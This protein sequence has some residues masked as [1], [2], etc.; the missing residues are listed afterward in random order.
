MGTSMSPTRALLILGAAA[1]GALTATACAQILGADFDV[2]LADAGPDGGAGG[3][4]FDGGSVTSSSSSS[5]GSG[6]GDAGC[7][8]GK[9]LA[10][11]VSKEDSPRGIATAGHWVY[12]TSDGSQTAEGTIKRTDV[13][14]PVPSASKLIEGLTKPNQIAVDAAHV[15][16]TDTVEGSVYCMLLSGAITPTHVVSSE[17]GPIGILVDDTSVYWTSSDGL[18]RRAPLG[19]P[20][21]PPVPSLVTSGLS[22]PALLAR[23]GGEVFVTEYRSAGHVLRMPA[24]GG[25]ATPLPMNVVYDTPD[26]ITDRGDFVCFATA[27]AGGS[28]YCASVDDMFAA[29]SELVSG[30][31]TPAGLTVDRSNGTLYWANSGSNVIM[32][33]DAGASIP[34]QV[35]SNQTAA[36]GIVVAG[37]YLYWTNSTTVANG[38]GV[39][40]LRIH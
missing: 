14:D 5:G 30:Q 17:N 18:V 2:K 6:G 21:S 10:E 4:D 15:Y 13:L 33:L 24:D 34:D 3:S 11:V 29:P 25:A 38:G 37:D 28:I 26:G 31:N 7:E 16:W 12:W 32:K 22:T 40:R 36:N 23:S 9:C 27:L 20:A 35:A 1:L 19:C 39:M 8:I